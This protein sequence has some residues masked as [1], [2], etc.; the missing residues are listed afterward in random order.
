MA[1]HKNTT[2]TLGDVLERVEGADLPPYQRRDLKRSMYD[3]IVF[4][5]VTF[6][7]FLT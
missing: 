7:H 1:D 4:P 5:N 3:S 6:C 2:T